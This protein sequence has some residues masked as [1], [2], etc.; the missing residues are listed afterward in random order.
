MSID[1][2]E[3]E[4]TIEYHVGRQLMPIEQRPRPRLIRSYVWCD[5]HGEIHERRRDFYEAHEEDCG[6]ANWRKVYIASDDPD[7]FK[8][9]R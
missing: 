2:N 3:L 9:D 8:D 6:D 5:F 7:E 1:P 4:L